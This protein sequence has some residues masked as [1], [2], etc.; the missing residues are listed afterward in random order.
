MSITLVLDNF[1]GGFFVD[2]EALEA[3]LLK[4]LRRSLWLVFLGF[5]EVLEWDHD[6][7]HKIMN[8]RDGKGIGGVD[9][10]IEASKEHSI[11]KH[12]HV[13]SS[14]LSILVA[15]VRFDVRS[16]EVLGRLVSFKLLSKPGESTS[17]L[18]IVIFFLYCFYGVTSKEQLG[19]MFNLS[20]GLKIY[21]GLDLQPSPVKQPKRGKVQKLRKGKP[22]LQLID[23]DEPTQPEPEPEPEHQGKGE[24]YDV[25]HAIQMSLESFQ[26]QSQA[27]VGGVAIRELVA[28]ATRPLPVIEGKGKAIA[29]DEQD[30]ASTNIV[31]ESPSLTDAETGADTD[32]T[33]SGGDTEILQIGEEQGDDVTNLVNLEEKTA[34]I[35]E[36]QVGSD[37]GQTP[38]SR[39]PPDDDKIDEDQAGPDPRESRMALAGPNPVGNY[40]FLT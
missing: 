3:I 2:D 34:E 7:V 1:L 37:P 15:N 36:G 35:D 6:V 31:H 20:V 23:K 28:E 27:H 26:A 10:S 18:F 38:K 12:H 32:K 17:F 29:T 14:T 40:A 22:S 8:V 30:D 25:E 5:F 39:P 24:E 9:M 13:A 16:L 19:N 4:R 11:W 21:L 33:N